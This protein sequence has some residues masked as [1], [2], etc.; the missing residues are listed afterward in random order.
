[1][2]NRQKQT[3]KQAL[4]LVDQYS[5][6]DAGVVVITRAWGERYRCEIRWDSGIGPT[7]TEWGGPVPLD[8][9][10][11]YGNDMKQAIFDAVQRCQAD[12]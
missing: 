7:R 5:G 11:G 4:K 3:I 8:K 12:S 1:M 6:T 2:A 9:V 10:I